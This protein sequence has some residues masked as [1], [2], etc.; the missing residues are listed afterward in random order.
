MPAN[1]LDKTCNIDNALEISETRK[2]NSDAT[3]VSPGCLHSCQREQKHS[4]SECQS[5]PQQES[6][7]QSSFDDSCRLSKERDLVASSSIA[8]NIGPASGIR[9]INSENVGVETNARRTETHDNYGVGDD[10]C[11]KEITGVTEANATTTAEKVADVAV[12]RDANVDQGTSSSTESIKELKCQASVSNETSCD[13][14]QNMKVSSSAVPDGIAKV[15]SSAPQDGIAKASLSAVSDCIVKVNSTALQVGI[16]EVS[17]SAVPDDVIKVSSSAQPDGPGSLTELK[18][19]SG[20]SGSNR[21]NDIKLDENAASSSVKNVGS[22]TFKDHPKPVSSDP[23]SVSSNPNPVSSDLDLRDQQP[24][25]QEH[26]EGLKSSTSGLVVDLILSKGSADEL[27]ENVPAVREELKSDIV[28]MDAVDDNNICSGNDSVRVKNQ[29]I[30][31]NSLVKEE[32]ADETMSSDAKPSQLSSGMNVPT[33]SPAGES[34][35]T[36]CTVESIPSSC[37]GESNS[38]SCTGEFIPSSY[39]GEAILGS[40]SD[41]SIPLISTGESNPTSFT[42]ESSPTS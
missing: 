23:D 6:S 42:G 33:P 26:L 36:S 17:L 35:S 25:Q 37:T 19:I 21:N 22:I 1:T 5:V 40:C 7:A 28:N 29:E 34:H 20:S 15:G 24:E 2:S 30:E 41:E 39:T 13:N 8:S 10:C 38:T 14:D 27:I 12:D 31:R 9:V 18:N 16:T 4:E 3:N 32:I 11:H